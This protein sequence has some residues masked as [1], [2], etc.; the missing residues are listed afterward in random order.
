MTRYKLPDMTP[1]Q[2]EVLKATAIWDGV[3]LVFQ[4]IIA[5]VLATTTWLW[6]LF[7]V[8]RAIGLI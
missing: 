3:K 7:L 5:G 8:S 4:T 2:M 6:L 1:E